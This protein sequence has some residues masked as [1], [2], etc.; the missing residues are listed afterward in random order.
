[1]SAVA[2]ELHGPEPGEV[3]LSREAIASRVAD[4]GAQIAR[5]HREANASWC[6]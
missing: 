2:R 1:M 6:C 5:D 4:L 3:Y